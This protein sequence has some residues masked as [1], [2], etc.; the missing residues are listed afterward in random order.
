MGKIESV[1]YQYLYICLFIFIKAENGASSSSLLRIAPSTRIYENSGVTILK[2]TYTT[3]LSANTI[4]TVNK[5]PKTTTVS[6]HLSQ[7]STIS[8]FSCTKT[9]LGDRK[10]EKFSGSFCADILRQDNRT[11]VSRNCTSKFSITDVTLQKMF[12]LLETGYRTDESCLVAMKW[13]TCSVMFPSCNSTFSLTRLPCQEVCS[14]VKDRLCLKYWRDFVD[15]Q[16]TLFNYIV[17]PSCISLP[18]KDNN[19]IC[20]YPAFIKELISNTLSNSHGKKNIIIG[21]SV[22]VSIVIAVMLVIS[23]MCCRTRP[24]HITTQL[25]MKDVKEVHQA[26]DNTKRFSVV[27]ILGETNPEY[28]S[29]ETLV[30]ALGIRVFGKENLSFDQN[31]GEGAFGKVVQCKTRNIRDASN[32]NLVAVKYLKPNASSEM[33]S[34]FLKE[35]EILS[36]FDHPNVIPLVGVC[37]DPEGP[38]C[39]VLEYMEQGDLNQYIRARSG[40]YHAVAGSYGNLPDGIDYNPPEL[41]YYNLLLITSQVAEGVHY[42]STKRFVHRDIASRNI[43]VG[44]NLQVKISDFGLAHDIYGSDY[45]RV[46]S[47]KMLPLRWLSPEALTLGKFTI[48]SDIWAFGVTMWEIFTYGMQPFYGCTNE[49]VCQRIRCHKNL[50]RPYCCPQKV[51][52]LMKLCWKFEPTQRKNCSH[53]FNIIKTWLDDQESFIGESWQRLLLPPLPDRR[54]T[55]KKAKLKYLNIRTEVTL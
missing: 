18:K 52:E 5:K 41:S 8:T 19:G 49:E 30:D 45:Y 44:R 55:I 50:E 21:V 51:Y 3:K 13:L 12:H 7:I 1:V 47:Q 17:I 48:Y 15:L 14:V 43:L 22:G 34:T 29:I 16:E 32:I 31:L 46:D 11:I 33:E 25:S 38:M 53:V 35:V 6:M 10:C 54:P 27:D 9:W 24:K 39:L 42:L 23:L 37:L 20:D 28:E 2:N 26:V 4:T 36:N 40:S